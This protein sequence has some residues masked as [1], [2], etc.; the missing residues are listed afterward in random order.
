[1]NIVLQGLINKVCLVYLDDM[2]IFGETLDELKKNEQTVKNCLDKFKLI[3]NDEKSI[4]GQTEIEFLGYKISFNKILPIESRA[5]GILN[6]PTQKNKTELR[7]FLGMVNFNRLF[8]PFIADKLELLHKLTSEKTQFV[9]SDKEKRLFDEV[10]S[11]FSRHVEL[12]IPD[13]N[14]PFI[15]ETDASE[16]GLGALLRQGNNPIAYASRV[17]NSSEC[18]YGISEKEF[19]ALI[20]GIQKFEYFLIGKPFTVFTDHQP[21]VAIHKKGKFATP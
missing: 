15:L 6:F 7:Q 10:K 2:L 20:W 13:M 4:W 16:K 12:T 3:V 21:L 1:M 8:L 5:S 9:W 19:L 11:R 18:N 14:I 17:L